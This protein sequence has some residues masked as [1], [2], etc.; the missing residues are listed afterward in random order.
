MG[1]VNFSVNY[2]VKDS[3]KNAT[4]YDLNSDLDGKT[5]LA[6]LLRFTKKALITISTDVLKEEQD[7]GFDKQPTLIV[8]NKFNKKVDDVNPLGKIEYVARVEFKEMI[9]ETYRKILFHSKVVTGRYISGNVVVYNG[10]QVANN[11]PSLEAWL[12]TK[13]IFSPRDIV[14]FVNYEP[15]ARKLET[16]G[17]TRQR[18]KAT[19][20]KVIRKKKRGRK[21]VTL[22]NGAYAMAYASIKRRFKKNSF[23][24]FDL[25]PGDRLGLTGEEGRFKGKRAKKKGYWGQPYIYPT[26]MIRAV[27]AGLT[28]T[29]GMLQ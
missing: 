17:V 15:Y 19:P 28:D 16:L 22:P 12:K 13:S 4:G 8:D 2:S 6:D 9:M 26:I 23:I 10:K 24:A 5:T 29:G 27:E 7:R 25:M 3:G 1:A 14:R 18:K 11:M 20:K 21:Q